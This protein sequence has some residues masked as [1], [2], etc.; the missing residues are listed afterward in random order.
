VLIDMGEGNG[1]IMVQARKPTEVK[2]LELDSTNQKGKVFEAFGV[3]SPLPNYEK[4][5][6]C[7]IGKADSNQK[8]GL[9]LLEIE[10]P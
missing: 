5:L 8:G 4:R 2:D 9:A 10:M 1:Q 6:V 7:G 3:L